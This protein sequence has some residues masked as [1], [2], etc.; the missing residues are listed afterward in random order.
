MSKVKTKTF[1]F[2]EV[3]QN[4]QPDV[5]I[6]D[7]KLRK[8]AAALS[9]L[10]Q[11]FD[12]M[13]RCETVSDPGDVADIQQFVQNLG[14]ELNRI[15]SQFRENPTLLCLSPDSVPDMLR[16]WEAC[17]NHPLTIQMQESLVAFRPFNEIIKLKNITALLA[18]IYGPWYPFVFAPRLDVREI[19]LLGNSHSNL[20]LS[21]MIKFIDQAGEIHNAVSSSNYDSGKMV[22]QVKEQIQSLINVPELSRCKDAI[23]YLLDTSADLGN[24][25]DS[26]HL[27][28]ETS[29]NPVTFLHS[30][31]TNVL[32]NTNKRDIRVIMQMK[33]IIAFLAKSLHGAGDKMHMSVL[34]TVNKILGNDGKPFENES[35]ND[36]APLTETEKEEF[37]QVDRD[38]NEVFKDVEDW[39]DE[40]QD[41]FNDLINESD[42]T[43]KS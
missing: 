10:R 23:K 3:M 29:G 13:L 30:Y 4:L 35:E 5:Y 6:L 1:N 41:L 39:N 27:D 36:P 12:I 19:L 15:P 2:G 18:K 7:A 38:A 43:R 17:K 11:T 16:I 20:L 28:A 21:V 42:H 8:I 24:N 31:I 14:T 22:S 33:K 26:Y 25:F 34:K 32:N 37:D 9:V 40:N